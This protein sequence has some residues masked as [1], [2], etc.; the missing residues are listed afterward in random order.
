MQSCV[1]R[2]QCLCGQCV[3]FHRLCGNAFDLLSPSPVMW[4]WHIPLACH[5]PMWRR[6]HVYFFPSL[7]LV[8]LHAFAQQ[9]HI[10]LSTVSNPL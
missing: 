8:A 4:Q 10:L 9:F 6:F 7:A 3:A 5:E 2:I 1:P